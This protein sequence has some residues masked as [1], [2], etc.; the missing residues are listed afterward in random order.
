MTYSLTWLPEVLAG[1]S[2]KVAEQPGWH[3]RGRGDMRTVRGVMC[4]HTATAGGGNMP[5]LRLLTNGRTDLSG[6]LAQLGLA[7]DGT[8]YVIAAGRANHAGLGKWR[9][10]TAGNSSFIGIE[11]ENS[12]RADDSWPEVQMDAYVRGVAAILTKIGASAD[13]CCG[14]KEFA[15]PL[16]RKSDP[17]FDMAAFRAR[18]AS[19]LSGTALVRPLI[20]PA[21]DQQ[22]PTLRRGAR[23]DAVKRVQEKVAALNDGIFGPGTEAAVRRFQRSRG[24]VPDGIVGPRTWAEIDAA[25]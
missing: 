24:I 17:S 18:V 9:G 19:V 23:G 21:D 5:S 8:F 15:L 4:H 10:V 20:P 6:P 16:G 12:G 14:H 2:L 11:A 3:S 7:R 22:R 25:S 13:M 1:A